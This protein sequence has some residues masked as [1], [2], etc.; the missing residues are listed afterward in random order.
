MEQHAKTFR[1]IFSDASIC[2]A[3]RDVVSSRPTEIA[4]RSGRWALSISMARARAFSARAHFGF[5]MGPDVV[6]KPRLDVNGEREDGQE[7]RERRPAAAPPTGVFRAFEAGRAEDREPIKPTLQVVRKRAGRGVS[8]PWVF[9]QAGLGDRFEV[10]RQIRDERPQWGGLAGA[11]QV[12]GLDSPTSGLERRTSG[13]AA[14]QRRPES[15]HI[16]IADR[17]PR[18]FPAISLEPHETRGSPHSDRTETRSPSGRRRP[19]Q[20]RSRRSSARDPDP[21]TRRASRRARCSEGLM[22]R[23]SIPAMDLVDGPCAVAINPT[24]TRA[25][26]GPVTRPARLPQRSGRGRG[27][28]TRLVRPRHGAGRRWDGGPARSPAASRIA[29]CDPPHRSQRSR[30]DDLDGDVAGQLRLPRLIDDPH[31]P[32]PK[33]ALDHESGILG[34]CSGSA[35]RA[36]T[37]SQGVVDASTANSS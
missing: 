36:L 29:P 11:H 7:R 12:H 23:C 34:G 9:P 10:A 2:G 33:L 26:Q 15:E 18:E 13:Q 1:F 5:G 6:S 37:V 20:F 35:S 24:A 22:S 28:D 19:G 17:S 4:N 16:R 3:S 27:R 25:R 14:V 32:A 31:S 21:E 30:H 8:P